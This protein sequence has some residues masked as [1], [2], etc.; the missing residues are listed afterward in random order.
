MR[1]IIESAC[2]KK[3]LVYL[4]ETKNNSF[5]F[6]ILSQV[7]QTSQS[8]CRRFF[9]HLLENSRLE[10]LFFLN[11]KISTHSIHLFLSKKDMC[12]CSFLNL[13]VF[14]TL[15]FLMLCFVTFFKN[16]LF[17]FS[18]NLSYI[19]N[20]FIASVRWLYRELN[21]GLLAYETSVL[22]LNYTAIARVLS[23]NY[24]AKPIKG[25]TFKKLMKAF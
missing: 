5:K 9:Q 2:L 18:N 17:S 11:D 16:F 3:Y 23:L 25:H 10:A 15:A 21:S 22:P 14:Y 1:K 24:R 4:Q 12:R 8:F 7:Q 6:S 19:L 13:F 20:L